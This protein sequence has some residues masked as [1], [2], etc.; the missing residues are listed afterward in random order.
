MLRGSLETRS[1]QQ[2]IHL[3]IDVKSWTLKPPSCAAARPSCCP[4]CDAASREPGRALVIVGHGLR[5]R[6]VDG[7]LAPNEQSAATSIVTRRY[8]C[9]AC[10]A[11]LIV[12]PRGVG[13]RYRYSLGAIAW[14]L[15]QWAYA[16]V[17]SAAVRARV[18]T[19]KN[20]GAASATRWA[21]LQ[22]WTRCALALFGATPG[23]FGTLRERAARIATFVAA[24]APLTTGPVPYDAFY[25]AAF[26]TSR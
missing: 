6:T 22:R 5:E 15:A 9:R 20:V 1:Q 12:A 16:R 2:I 25:G 17:P 13:A 7:P 19:A 21:S 4:V 10:D 14:A 11:I 18:S 23:E 8:R 24:H 26:C 3:D